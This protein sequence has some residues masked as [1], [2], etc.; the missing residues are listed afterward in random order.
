MSHEIRTPMNGIIGMTELALT[1]D[2]TGA[3]RE[4]M[5]TVR[6]SSESL[7]GLLNSIL[8][9]SKIESRKLELESVP[10]AL[11][12][13]IAEALKPL[14]FK[15]DEK[16]VELLCEISP[17]APDALVGD[18]LRLR[19]IVTNLVSNAVKFTASGH[20]LLAIT[21]ERRAEGC[22][23]LRFS[24]SDT[25]P[26]IPAEKHL[27]IF[28]P[29][30]QA[31]GSTTRRYGGTGL[32]LAISATLVRLMGGRIWVDSALGKGSTFSFTARFDVTTAVE[33]SAVEPLLANLPVLVVDDN[34]INRRIF[35][36]QLAR[37][38]MKASLA[39]GGR[40][41]IAALDAAA[42]AAAPFLLVLLDANMPEIDGFAVAEHIHS[43][44][45]L[46]G[47][48]I[49]MLTSAGHY[50]DAD[51]C[52]ALNISA[53][54]TKPIPPK[55]LFEAICRVVGRGI[56]QAP[57][58]PRPARP[59]VAAAASD[60]RRVLLA[61]DN[62][63]NQRVAIGLLTKRG[64]EVT[65]AANGLEA[66]EALERA[67]FDIVLMDVQ[68]PEMGGLEATAEI[69]RRERGTDRHIQIVAMTAHAMNGDREQCLA[70]G[71][72]DYLSKPVN[73]AM[74]YSVVEQE[75]EP[76]HATAAAAPS[77]ARL[78]QAVDSDA[79]RQRRR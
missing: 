54:L 52:R 71:M 2:L 73:P 67:T 12:D 3:Q 22:T 33:P 38:G 41:A 6:A 43:R 17:E 63:V 57:A 60:Y 70:A 44:P 31:D 66:L 10:F 13:M 79:L 51:R 40:A 25:G 5:Q 19:Q 34:A 20:V 35:A 7:L 75:W 14:A 26:G 29:F 64:H 77:A 18:P 68:M 8:D 74:L 39:D 4:H 16:S 59:S 11:R 53:Y 1:T 36:E 72:D 32:G 49:M 46:A 9:F 47:A 28:E 48:T 15:A 56:A 65:L 42:A 24:V 30:S 62:V 27:A 58:V 69:R 76:E 50:G 23:R 78:H 55:H 61:E 37:W 21:E 45:A